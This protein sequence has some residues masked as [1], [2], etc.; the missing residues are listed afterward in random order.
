VA[1]DNIYED[2]ELPVGTQPKG[3]Q[4]KTSRPYVLLNMVASADGKAAIDGKASR[5]GT[6]TDRSVMRTLRSRADAVMV[7][8]GTVRAER[9]SLS[10]DPEDTRPVPR[11]VILTSTGELPLENN[12]VWDHRQEVLV[13]L[14]E[15]ADKGVERRLGR[16]AETRK[17]PATE[18]G[19]IDVESALK[20]MKSRYG[21]DILLCEGG[22]ELLRTLISADLADELFITVAPVLVGSKTAEEPRALLQDR[23]GGPRSLGLIS[24]YV[25]GDELFLRYTIKPKP[26]GGSRKG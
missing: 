15:N 14:P 20:T 17:V 22:P 2:I 19:A 3:I 8:G 16:F 18:S 10:L 6:A 7:G 12:L 5:L 1:E 11:A 9:L 26:Y 13:L 21:I 25:V 24:S 23:P 4:T